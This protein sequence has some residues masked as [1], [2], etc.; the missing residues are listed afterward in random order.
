[1]RFPFGRGAVV[2]V[3]LRL[4]VV[5]VVRVRRRVALGVRQRFEVAVAIVFVFGGVPER[6]GDLDRA[7]PFVAFD[8]GRVFRRFGAF[9]VAA[10]ADARRLEGVFV[11]F[12]RALV[13]FGVGLR[14]AVALRVVLVLY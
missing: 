13:A 8:F 12:P 4:L 9:D 3:G 10:R 5:G 11:V 7:L 14:R 2:R 1:A 6:V